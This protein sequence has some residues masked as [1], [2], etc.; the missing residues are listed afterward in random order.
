VLILAMLAGCRG[1][2][3]RAKARPAAAASPEEMYSLLKARQGGLTAFAARGRLTLISPDQNATGTALIKAKFP[4]TLRVD[5]KDPLGRQALSFFT[6]GQ[7]V[8]V[9]FPREDKLFK[10]PAS[11]TNLASFIP[12]GIKVDQTLRLMAG[13]LPLSQS[14]PT[15]VKPGEGGTTILEWQGKGGA[16]KERLWVST[17][18]VMPQK[19]E[20]YGPDGT[21]VFTA[22]FGDWGQ[23][24]PDRPGHI[25]LVTVKPQVDLRLTYKEFTPNPA[26][27]PADLAIP[28]PAG[29]TEQP[30]QP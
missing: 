21:P 26:L 13:D 17:A 25:R 3:P 12:P 27:T 22:E 24:S 30:L 7:V 6:D 2:M 16:L 1:M 18:G 10:G 8:E 9:L 23:A 14:P 11:T 5:V 19:D 4:Q 29:V 28:R 20:W 15:A